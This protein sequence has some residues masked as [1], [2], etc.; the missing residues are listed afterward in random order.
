MFN[1]DFYFYFFYLFQHFWT[2]ISRNTKTKLNPTFFR[3]IWFKLYNL[4]CGCSRGFYS[5]STFKNCLPQMIHKPYLIFSI[6]LELPNLHLD[7]QFWSWKSCLIRVW[8]VLHLCSTTWVVKIQHPVPPPFFFFFFFV[9]HSFF[10][11]HL[12]WQWG[13]S[14]LR[15]LES[16][17]EQAHKRRKQECKIQHH[18]ETAPVIN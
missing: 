10:F 8:S 3:C 18:W 14:N 11:S 4:I 2:C 16:E 7:S 15:K 17:A 9:R 6:K 13:C 1:K 5:D 12:L